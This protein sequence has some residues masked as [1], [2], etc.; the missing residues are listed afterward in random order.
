M[1]L[2]E[3]HDVAPV[4]QFR[5]GRFT[6]SML[7]QCTFAI[8]RRA[9]LPTATLLIP[10]LIGCSSV[11]EGPATDTRSATLASALNAEKPSKAAKYT[12]FEAGPVRP[13]AVL[14]DGIVAVTNVPDDRVEL[15]RVRHDD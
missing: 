8:V 10:T 3:S 4:G 6:M 11:A 15:F 7:G 5:F 14:A 1:S 13:I 12:L 9:G 2:Y